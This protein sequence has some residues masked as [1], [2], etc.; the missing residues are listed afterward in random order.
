MQFVNHFL[1]NGVDHVC[2]EQE[3]LVTVELVFATIKD[4]SLL[5]ALCT[6]R[7]FQLI[8]FQFS[9]E[10]GALARIGLIA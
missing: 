2:K 1:S 6:R 3:V 10:I 5:T 7:N 9:L 8:C 4:E